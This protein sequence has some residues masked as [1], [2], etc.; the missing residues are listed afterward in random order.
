M[1]DPRQHL[2]PVQ[3]QALLATAR[4]RSRRDHLIF[5]LALGT[6]LS[7][8]AI[9]SLGVRDISKDGTAIEPELTLGPCDRRTYAANDNGVV[10]L[11][12]YLRVRLARHLR[13]MKKICRH[14]E[15][16]PMRTVI[17]AKGVRR[18]ETC[19]HVLDLLDMPLFLSRFRERLSTRRMRS[20]FEEYRQAVWLPKHLHFDSLKKTF[21]AEKITDLESA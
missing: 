16:M 5:M 21:D 6:G 15:T 1:I 13:A 14:F 3:Q 12:Q 17:D 4:I 19:G 2:L 11:P 7:A 10:M 20:L 8:R 9:S 18:C